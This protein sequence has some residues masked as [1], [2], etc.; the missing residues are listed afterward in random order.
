MK[1]NNSKHWSVGCKIAQWRINTQIHQTLKD[2][3][4]HLTYGQHPRVGI[5]N[6]PVAESVLAKLRTEAELNDVFSQMKSS[7]DDD[8]EASAEEALPTTTN[9]DNLLPDIVLGA[10]DET[11]LDVEFVEEGTADSDL[12]ITRSPLGKRKNRSPQ[13]SSISTREL[14][15]AKRAA[16]KNSFSPP[17]QD[18]SDAVVAI[19]F[20]S[21]GV[22]KQKDGGTAPFMR[23]IELIAERDGPVE[24][25]EIHHA[26]VNSVFPIVYCINNKDILDDRN[27][28]PCILRKVRKEQYELLDEQENDKVDEDLDWGGD[29][30]L[31]ASWSMYYKFPKK[32]FV[33]SVRLD[34]EKK[35]S[36]EEATN[37]SPK[38]FTLRKKAA[39]NVRKK[40]D[41]VTT[42]ALTK[43]PELVFKN[44]DVVLVPL[45]D[46]DRCKVD[47]GCLCGVVVSINKSKSTCRVA[48]EHG[49]L[50][51]AYVYHSLKAVPPTSNNID[52]M[53]LREAYDS[54]R[55]LPKITEREAARFI[56]SVGGQGM[57]HC[58]CRGACTTNGCSCRKAGRLCSSRCHRNSKCCENKQ[59]TETEQCYS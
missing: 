27:W 59:D 15:D 7:F 38:R 10:A 31:S 45:D 48:V 53:N 3:P 12:A 13:V 25:D 43:S 17:G 23:W 28:K 5:S 16:L 44:G 54:W 4:Y 35:I 40:G 52:A 36:E 49:L 26:S 24:L 14:R 6:L 21:P 42:K 47:G 11:A 20:P 33:D 8:K 55:S 29:E 46:V 22:G 1:S 30:G 58:N 51:R 56:S 18:S 41:K 19:D 32:S 37:V 39:E 9:E 57:V 50:H 2:T 34:L